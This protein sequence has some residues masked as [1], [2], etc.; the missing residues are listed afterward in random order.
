[1]EEDRQRE[2]Y[3]ALMSLLFRDFMQTAIDGCENTELSPFDPMLDVIAA[4]R[5]GEI[6]IVTD[7]EQRENEGDLICAA[8]AVT[9]QIINFMARYGRGLICVAMDEDRLRELDI[10]SLRRRGRRD[11]YNTAFMESV[12]ARDGI[13]TGISATDR[14][15]TIQLLVHE[16]TRHEDLV[17]PGHIF[18]LQAMPGGVLER[19]GHT[20]AAVDL[21]VLAGRQRAGVICEIIRDDGH[22]ARLPDLI[23]FA[24]AHGLKMTS[25]ADLIRYRQRM[26]GAIDEHS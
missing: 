26:E 13:T 15:R 11:H 10:R 8:D 2:L 24:A 3:F 12:D 23:D 14:A 17:S 4:V 22:M 18:P 6:V 1:M 25:V 9:P 21:A 16:D 5:C 19:P 7:D 20:E